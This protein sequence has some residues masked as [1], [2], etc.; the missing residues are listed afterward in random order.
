MGW[1]HRRRDLGN[2]LFLDI[3]DRTGIVQV[4]FNKETQPQAHAKAEQARGEFVVA[5]EGQVIKRKKPNPK[6]AP[7]EVELVATSLHILN[8]AKTPPFPVEDEINVAEETRLRYRYID[9]RRAKPHR[10]IAL[11][12]KIVL[13]IRKVMD[14]MG[15]I[16]VETPMLTRSTPEGARDYLVPSRVHHGQFYALPQS[17]QIFKQIL[18]IGGLDR[19]FQIVKCFRDEDLRADRQPEFTQLDLEMSF[20]RQEDIFQVIEK[21]MVRACAVAGVKAAAPF[22]HML[23]KDAIRKYG[24]DKPDLRFGMELHEVTDCFPQPI[25]EKLQIEGNVFAFT[26]PGA[27]TYSRKQLD[28][29]TEQAKSAG[30]RGAYFV[31]VSPEG[32]TS[33]VEKLIGAENVAKLATACEA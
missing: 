15:F 13:E 25:Q 19:Y 8:N 31:K 12:H 26:A 23:Y 1:V 32:T 33:T 27:A 30:A 29:L 6:L 24:S 9:L 4:V 18:M 7:G 14:E 11:R 17:P 10:N 20:P 5:V 28:E 2:L 16:E 22:P 21:V 3:R